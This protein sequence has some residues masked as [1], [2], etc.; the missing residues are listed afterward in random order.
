MSKEPEMCPGEGGG[1]SRAGAECASCNQAFKLF[2]AYILHEDKQ[3]MHR[4]HM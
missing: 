2:L 3:I 1:C 4:F